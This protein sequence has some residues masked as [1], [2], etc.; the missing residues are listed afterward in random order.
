MTARQMNKSKDKYYKYR[1]FSDIEH[2]MDILLEERLYCATLEQLNDP[3]EGHLRYSKLKENRKK[4][5]IKELNN[6]FICSLSKKHNKGLM[7]T[8]YANSH[9]GICIALNVTSKVWEHG[10]I[11]YVK[12]MPSVDNYSKCTPEDYVKDVLTKKS[13]DWQY[14]EE[15]R[16]IR[17]KGKGLD[18]SFA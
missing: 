4:E 9:Q 7:W 15:V 1:D 17:R 13:E 18:V 10:E 16:W 8:H 12:S 2:L 5:M 11:N 14:E 6:Y 3:M